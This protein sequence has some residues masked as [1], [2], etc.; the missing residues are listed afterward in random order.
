MRKLRTMTAA[1]ALLAGAGLAGGNA[2]AQSLNV[3]VDVDLP[4]VIFLYCFDGASAEISS[5]DLIAGL[6]AGSQSIGSGSTETVSSFDTSTAGELGTDGALS[7]LETLTPVAGDLTSINLALEG[8]CGVRATGTGGDVSVA[9]S[10]ADNLLENG[11][12]PGSTIDVTDL[13]LR[14]GSTSPGGGSGSFAP[15]PLTL[16][17]L[18]FSQIALID[19]LLNLDLT[20]ATDAG[21]YSSASDTFT[22]T[23][24]DP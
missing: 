13:Q 15:S 2:Q 17:T 19:V 16:P 14:A 1:C 11:T 4:S 5:G 8:I 24:S 18:G 6:G 20:N 9:G 7:G 3:D 21:V 10:I 12:N 23:V 22:I